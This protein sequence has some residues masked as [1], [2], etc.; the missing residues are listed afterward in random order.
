MP[1]GAMRLHYKR[2]N[3]SIVAD[4][5]FF[6]LFTAAVIAGNQ[7]NPQT[8]TDISSKNCAGQVPVRM[9]SL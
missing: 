9:I 6:H 2:V 4:Q 8:A 5:V 3:L 7:S 1:V